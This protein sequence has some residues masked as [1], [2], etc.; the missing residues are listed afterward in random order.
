ML[1][2]LVE[3][4]QRWGLLMSGVQHGSRLCMFGKALLKHVHTSGLVGMCTHASAMQA[5]MFCINFTSG[6][7]ITLWS[8]FFFF[9]QMWEN[10]CAQLIVA[11][12]LKKE[13]QGDRELPPPVTRKKWGCQPCS[14]RNR[15]LQ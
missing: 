6:S 13:P 1:Y 8:S 4:V 5:S 11:V 14:C 2:L 9:S 15:N 7:L 3:T 12:G 10:P